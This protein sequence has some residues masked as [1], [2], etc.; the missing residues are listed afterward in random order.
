MNRLPNTLIQFFEEVYLE[1]QLNQVFDEEE[2]N[3]NRPTDVPDY[4]DD[5]TNDPDRLEKKDSKDD[6]DDVLN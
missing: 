1:S 4:V 2:I 3:R 5:D 6:A